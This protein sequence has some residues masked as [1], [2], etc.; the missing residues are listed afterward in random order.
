ML[1]ILYYII[2]IQTESLLKLIVSSSNCKDILI[3]LV[4]T[5]LP[6]LQRKNKIDPMDFGHNTIENLRLDIIDSIENEITV[7]EIK[8]LASDLLDKPISKDETHE[9]IEST[10]KKK[11]AVPTN[12]AKAAGGGKK[13]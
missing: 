10:D 13:M 12:A 4:T 5:E 11:S 1:N 8:K 6:R 2:T 3:F 7:E 9:A